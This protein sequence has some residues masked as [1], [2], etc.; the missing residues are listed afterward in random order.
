M[1][2]QKQFAEIIDL[3]KRAQFSAF[4]AINKELINLYWEIGEYISKRTMQEGWGKST[5]QQLAA[6]IQKREPNIKGFSDKNLWRMKQLYD[7]YREDPKLST[8]LREISWSHNLAI[9]SKCK[10]NEERLFYITLSINENYT[11]R[12]LTR[13][14]DSSL[15]ERTIL[16]NKKLSTVL[17]EIPT[18][19]ESLFK[20][21]YVL[22]FLNLPDPYNETDLQKQLVQQIKKFIL[23]LGKDFL[24]M[25]EEYRLQVGNKDFY[26][27]LLFYHRELR[28]LVL[29]ELKTTDFEPTHLGQLNF[30]L[31]ALDRDVKK[32]HENPSIGILLCKNNDKEVVE[33]ALSRNVSPA[34]ISQYTLTL[35]DKKLLRSKLHEFYELISSQND[36]S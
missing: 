13:Q 19:S 8:V 27:D 4:H 9:L 10:T 21:T 2:I 16:G 34:L 32:P 1:N 36:I 25:G 26:T 17:R 30:Y 14:I 11:F 31:E 5:V 15:Y 3:I 18:K 22:E 20:E 33:Y 28:C 35:P 24:F 29:F 12:E 6:Y 7:T 23:E